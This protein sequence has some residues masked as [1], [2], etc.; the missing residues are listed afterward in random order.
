MN[1]FC[2]LC[3]T[4]I[5]F[6]T[7]ICSVS[8]V[9]AH[10]PSEDDCKGDVCACVGNGGPGGDSGG[11]GGP[12]GGGKGPDGPPGPSCIGGMCSLVGLPD[13]SVN[14][15]NLN[16]TIIDT[17]IAY[18]PALGPQ[19]RFTMTYNSVSSYLGSFGYYWTHSYNT[20]LFINGSYV[21]VKW[22]SGRENNYTCPS[23]G[24]C[25]GPIGTYN[26]L[27][28]NPDNTYTLEKKDHTKYEFDVTGKL[29]EIVDNYD[30]VLDLV[31]DDTGLCQLVDTKGRTTEIEYY[32]TGLLKKIILPD[33]RFTEFDYEDSNLTQVIDEAGE[34]TSYTYDTL[35][36]H[37]IESVSIPKRSIN[38][39]YQLSDRI[40]E[41][42]GDI[43]RTYTWGAWVNYVTDANGHQTAYPFQSWSD[44]TE[45]R[46]RVTSVTD[47]LNNST[48]YHYDSNNNVDQITDANGNTAYY[49]N[50]E[51][52]NRIYEQDALE[53]ETFY[54][55]Y[56]KDKIET[57]TDARGKLT[58]YVYGDSDVLL[59]VTE[60]DPLLNILSQ[61]TYEYTDARFPYLK[62][63]M[64]ANGNITTYTYDDYGRMIEIDVPELDPVTFSYD[65]LND[66]KISMTN[67]NG[68]TYYEYD[69][70][71][72]I[73]KITHPDGTHK[74]YTYNCCDLQSVRD[75]NGKITEY[76]YDELGRIIKVIDAELNETIYGYDGVGNLTSRVDGNGD[77]TIYQYDD[78]DRLT[79]I[80][81]PLG[82]SES[83]T[84]DEY[85]NMETK[86]D[87]NGIITTYEYDDLNRLV[88]TIYPGKEISYEYDEVG[89]RTQMEETE[90]VNIRTT[91]YTYDYLNRL[92]G[93]ETS[94][95][96]TA[97]AY[98][99]SCQVLDEPN[100]TYYLTK[101]LSGAEVTPKCINIQA[102][103]VTFDGQGHSI[104]ADLN[105]IAIYSDQP[106]TTIKNCNISMRRDWPNGQAFGI[107]LVNADNS[108]I[109]NN[110]LN[111]Q[112]AGIEMIDVDTAII[113]NNT[114]SSN[115]L[116][117]IN[118]YSNCSNNTLINNVTNSNYHYGIALQG[119]SHNNLMENHTDSN[120]FAGIFLLNSSNNIVSYTKANSNTF[121]GA[122]LVGGHDNTI[123][124]SEI[125]SNKF[126]FSIYQANNNTIKN[127]LIRDCEIGL[128][129][130]HSTYHEFINNKIYDNDYG[131]K[132]H[133][134]H[135]T[136]LDCG[137]VYDNSRYD[138]HL[139]S[140]NKDI[141]SRGIT[142]AKKYI[143]SGAEFTEEPSDCS[144]VDCTWEG[145]ECV[146][147]EALAG[148]S[149]ESVAI[150]SIITYDYD[151]NGNRIE[152]VTS[153]GI[154][155]YTYTDNSQL[156]SVI[157][158]TGT[159][160][161]GYDELG[162]QTLVVYPNGTYTEYTYHPTRNW[163]ESVTNR[164]SGGTVLSSFVYTH[165]NVGNRETMTELDGSVVTYLYNNIYELESETRTGTNPYTITYTYDN[166][167]NRLTMN[168]TVNS[169]L[170]TVNYDYNDNNQ[171]VTEVIEETD[172]GEMASSGGDTLT[173]TTLP[174]DL[175]AETL[176][177]DEVS[178]VGEPDK[179]EETVSVLRKPKNYPDISGVIPTTTTDDEGRLSA[180]ASVAGDTE[181][182]QDQPQFYVFTDDFNREHI[183]SNWFLVNG[184]WEII[185][186]KLTNIDA[187]L[188]A[189]AKA[190][191][192]EA[193]IILHNQYCT[194]ADEMEIEV[195]ITRDEGT[196]DD[197]RKGIVFGYT[198][199]NN[200]YIVGIEGKRY[201]VGEYRNGIYK[202]LSSV[203]GDNYSWLNLSTVGNELKLK[204]G[205]DRSNYN[206]I[207]GLQMKTPEGGVG[208][209]AE[210]SNSFDNFGYFY[211]FV[212]ADTT[213]KESQVKGFK[214]F[215]KRL[216]TLGTTITTFTYSYDDNGNLL[217]KTDGINT[218]TYTWD[219]E[220]RLVGTT[221][222]ER[223]TQYEYDGDGN[224]IS[225]TVDG[226]T[227]KYIND[228]AAPL[229]QVLME[230][231]DEDTVIASYT[232]G[233][234]LISST[235][236]DVLNTI[237]YNYDGLGSVRQLTDDT[238]AIVA[239]YTYDA[240][241]NLIASSGT[242]ENTYGFTGEQQFKEAD[243]LVYLRARYYDARVGRFISR[244]PILEPRGVG[245]NFVW[246]LPYLTS[247]PQSLQAYEYCGNNPVNRIDPTGKISVPPDALACL[248]C[249]AA[250][251]IGCYWGCV[252][253]PGDFCDYLE[254]VDDCLDNMLELKCGK[255]CSPPVPP[256]WS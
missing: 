121:S 213:N 96:K 166:A 39:S 125:Y 193:G 144:Y 100:A 206:H 38:I 54:T 108:Y 74:E 43:T 139:S 51:W 27:T 178:V 175:S 176:V 6:V 75:E 61:I 163:L 99:N 223:V 172:G 59:S 7:L 92:I 65:D 14:M 171:L 241:G 135:H 9:Y 149:I 109:Y 254:C 50:N 219:Y 21:T 33:G 251:E 89:N 214:T 131:I 81:Y 22:G 17:P 122:S 225:K 140:N 155:T 157:A 211:F 147:G 111:N 47:H 216:V 80:I 76:E 235:K 45:L 42:T 18:T 248:L 170:V 192:A 196:M 98:V 67:A 154:T 224:R 117:G 227:T 97:F 101:D 105:G 60:K 34:L 199:S 115:Y 162:N 87:G 57:I 66:R 244:D 141:I 28:K 49:D 182:D 32:D 230:T 205:D 77:T 1:K 16:L 189:S 145:D 136:L 233:N 24:V 186:E 85:G 256:D 36:N 203:Q 249:M 69:D 116:S 79:D 40:H 197:G 165:D 29:E 252:G 106:Y 183:G 71:D 137:E 253:Y 70:L 58:E 132:L 143:A 167:G 212:S 169:T 198:N 250:V 146:G 150:N 35:G 26:T 234:D 91:I 159:T 2:F 240:F 201:F 127:N 62:T 255:V 119:S 158:P 134:A 222:D 88:K 142:Y 245:N 3:I 118:L 221:E 128:K 208:L 228:I 63:S 126:G 5:L 12:G 107:K 83:Y 129:V 232:Y 30:N 93:T 11:D 23:S 168:K 95:T 55:Y 46:R 194:Q 160:T 152:M 8:F 200:Y 31:Y 64:D 15:T 114:A 110:I 188:P 217:S 20:Y 236:Y 218:T 133:G 243:G 164:N 207:L 185:N 151:A 86:T 238:E 148:E 226:V 68:T 156:E 138:I 4:F 195:N 247:Q 37:L 112:F 124:H 82:D 246:L 161:Y 237:Y 231:T 48:L 52:G 180:D 103:N 10:H 53:N 104:I 191:A 56:D 130:E 242:S 153:E 72:R 19:V 41:I 209:F 220:N 215:L 94:H 184:N 179:T 229:V 84:Y 13:L 90:G 177:K 123:S 187:G 202:E 78:A 102:E 113:E 210:S 25:T 204:A 239:L 120:L 190:S 174:T 181:E 173:T 73:K 44:G